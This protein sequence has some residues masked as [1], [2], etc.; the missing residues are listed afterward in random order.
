M[1]ESKALIMERLRREDRW[2]EASLFK[3]QTIKEL[4]AAGKTR[5]DAGELA[6]GEMARKYP[7]VNQANE[8]VD[9]GGL[10]PTQEDLPNSSP[11]TFVGDAFWVYNSIGRA[12]VVSASAPSAGAWAL[13]RWAERN[14]DRFFEQI[15]PKALQLSTKLESEQHSLDH[16]DEELGELEELLGI[17]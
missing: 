5:R 13:L 6:W 15:L 11:A 3:D 10:D 7:P 14:E 2:D 12:T 1:Q 16:E 8:G 17:C 9:L 4:R